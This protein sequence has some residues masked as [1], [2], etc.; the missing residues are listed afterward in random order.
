[1][2]EQFKAFQESLEAFL[3]GHPE[4][5]SFEVVEEDGQHFIAGLSFKGKGISLMANVTP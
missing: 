4:I 2:D 5:E 3:L 1:M